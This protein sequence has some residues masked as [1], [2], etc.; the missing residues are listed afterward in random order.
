ME[1]HALTTSGIVNPCWILAFSVVM[2]LA[3]FAARADRIV[4]GEEFSASW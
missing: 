3:P 4:L 2:T 1:R